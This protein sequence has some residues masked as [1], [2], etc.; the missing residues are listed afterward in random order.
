[1]R[2]FQAWSVCGMVSNGVILRKDLPRRCKQSIFGVLVDFVQ[3]FG[4]RGR[5]R[6]R[7]GERDR[8]EPAG[9]AR[10]RNTRKHKQTMAHALMLNMKQVVFVVLARRVVASIVRYCIAIGIVLYCDCVCLVRLHS[11]EMVYEI[12]D[13]RAALSSVFDFSLFCAQIVWCGRDF[14]VKSVGESSFDFTTPCVC[15]RHGLYVAWCQMV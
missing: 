10:R 6:A 14:V 4:K 1:M 9:S 11:L 13:V 8:D 2:L 5:E 12:C 7:E 3:L 15:F